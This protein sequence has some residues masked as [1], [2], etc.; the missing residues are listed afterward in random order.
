MSASRALGF[1]VILI[2]V[3]YLLVA[4]F[5]I[6]P[7]YAAVDEVVAQADQL[8]LDTSTTNLRFRMGLE[9]L[10]DIVFIAALALVGWWLT[11]VETQQFSYLYVFG[12]LFI[13]A[14]VV[15]VTPVVPVSVVRYSPGAAFFGAKVTCNAL[16]DDSR[17]WVII[18]MRQN[19][20]VAT[21]AAPG[22][23]Q[24]TMVVLDFGNDQDAMQRYLASTPP[25]PIKAVVYGTFDIARRNELYALPRFRVQQLGR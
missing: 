5:D 8:G 19:L 21:V 13:V 18:P 20:R 11:T 9:F 17:G 7:K 22:Q 10:V 1:V 6:G 15:R 2:A 23:Q 25:V 16:S 14:I 12:A 3:A 24:G 4:L